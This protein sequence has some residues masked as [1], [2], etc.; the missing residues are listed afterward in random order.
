[1][2]SSSR[3]ELEQVGNVIRRCLEY[4]DRNRYYRPPEVRAA[5]RNPSRNRHRPVRRQLSLSDPRQMSFQFSESSRNPEQ[6][7]QDL[8]PEAYR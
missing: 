2:S 1:M 6:P 3:G 4:A 8:F 7:L 5:G